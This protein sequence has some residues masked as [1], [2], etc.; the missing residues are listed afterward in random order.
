MTE[1]RVTPARTPAR[2]TA[3]APAG[4]AV[5]SRIPE[6]GLNPIPPRGRRPSLEAVSPRLTG[7]SL[8]E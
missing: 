2:G 7:R 6:Q 1:N 8:V 4:A 5:L 3:Y